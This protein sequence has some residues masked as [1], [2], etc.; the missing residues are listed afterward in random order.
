MFG[1]RIGYISPLSDAWGIVGLV[2]FLSLKIGQTFGLDLG[3]IATKIFMVDL[4]EMHLCFS[5]GIHGW[6]NEWLA[7]KAPDG[8][9]YKAF[10][11]VIVIVHSR[12]SA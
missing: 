3:F 9:L 6:I 4:L 8:Y 11:N 7:P 12:L 5:Q 2:L 10:C 1:P